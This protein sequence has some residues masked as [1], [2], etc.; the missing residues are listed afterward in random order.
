VKDAEDE[1]EI[2]EKPP[3]SYRASYM[4]PIAAALVAL[5]FPW[6]VFTSVRANHGVTASLYVS[7]FVKRNP[8]TVNFVATHLGTLFATITAYLFSTAVVRFAQK[9]IVHLG[10]IDMLHISFFTDL[11]HQRFPGSF[12]HWSSAF[13]SWRLVAILAVTIVMFNFIPSGI[14]V[15]LSPIPFNRTVPLTG[16]EVDFGSSVPDCVAW[17]KQPR[18]FGDCNWA[19][20]S[21][22]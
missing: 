17:L 19:V 3:S 5:A 9:W 13:R 7:R 8:Q 2:Q 16:T 22:C 4:S 1:V 10:D 21:H 11:R 12:G 18:I 20:S 14:S 6:V 15:L